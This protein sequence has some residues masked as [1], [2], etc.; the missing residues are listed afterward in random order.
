[1]FPSKYTVSANT[2]NP[3]AYP[4]YNQFEPVKKVEVVM[5]SETDTDSPYLKSVNTT[6]SYPS[7]GVYKNLNAD[8]K[9]RKR[10][11]KYFYFKILDEWLDDELSHI[12]NYLS[13]KNGKIK[14]KKT[15]IK[16]HE[17]KDK[18]N[19]RKKKADYI[20]KY[21]LEKKHVYK[22]L[23]KYTSKNKVNW[24]DLIKKHENNLIDEFSSLLKSLI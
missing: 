16:H 4:F 17:N 20:E 21:V 13:H 11:T 9:I 1:M 15:N 12:L 6:Y 18:S 23:D 10:I 19:V 7:V 14:K 8:P 22:L 3:V 2:L 5:S 24:Y